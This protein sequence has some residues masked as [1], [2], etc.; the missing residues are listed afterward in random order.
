MDWLFF[1]QRTPPA[2]QYFICSECLL[3]CRDPEKN[4]G[5]VWEDKL[6]SL[7]CRPEILLGP[8]EERQ[9]RDWPL[10]AWWVPVLP[11]S[12]VILSKLPNVSVPGLS[13]LQNGGIHSSQWSW[14]VKCSEQSRAHYRCQLLEWRNLTREDIPKLMEYLKESPRP[15]VGKL[16]PMGQIQFVASFCK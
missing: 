6:W 10:A 15:G 1:L 8:H 16:S 13:H 11:L 7:P 5:K 2:L 9:Q 3:S 12:C 4:S 14:C